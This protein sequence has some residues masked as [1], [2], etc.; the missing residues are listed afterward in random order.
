VLAKEDEHAKDLIALNHLG[1]NG[2][3]LNEEADFD[4]KLN[5]IKKDLLEPYLIRS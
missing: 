2:H 3:S 4:E 5:L 1:T